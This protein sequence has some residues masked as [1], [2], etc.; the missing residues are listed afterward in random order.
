MSN[1]SRLYYSPA[2]SSS[3]GGIQRLTTQHKNA[4]QIKTHNA[5]KWL[6]GQ[7]AYTLHKPVRKHFPRRRTIVA[8]IGEQ[9]QVDLID[10]QKYKKENSG[11]SFL[12]S[13][14]D[15]FSKKAYLK[16]LKSK[17]AD[18]VCSALEEILQADHFRSVQSDKGR[19]F[20]NAQVQK[21]LKGRGVTHF[22]SEN[23]N[24]KASI[25][26]RFNRTL[27]NSIHRWMT[28]KNSYRY[29]EILED[30]VDAYNNAYHSSIGMAPN[31]V[32]L[33][34]QEDVWLKLYPPT[35]QRQKVKLKVGD[36]VR[37]SKARQPF[38]KSYTASWS[39]EVYIVE[40]VE[41]TSPP[42]YKIKDLNNE[43]ILGTFYHQELQL[44]DKPST[45][46]IE[47]VLKRKT[48]RGKQLV[49]VKWLGYPDSFNQWIDRKD[50]E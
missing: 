37:I 45:Y 5:I 31:K 28:Y 2:L 32:N 18:E 10:M 41:K 21:M 1:L 33:N 47:K 34:N 8:G 24:I 7:E 4:T 38:H 9:L 12:L 46:R 23:E 30:L 50:V 36:Y 26:E 29:I 16:M 44:V 17:S 39:T 48:V 27:Q 49:F 19:E 40:S 14:V 22:T 13:A 35:L 3:L 43:N 25:V 6:R 15:V 20:I 11:V 42:V